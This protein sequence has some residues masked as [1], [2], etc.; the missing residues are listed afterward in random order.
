MNI[1]YLRI[2]LF[3]LVLFVAGVSL[4]AATELYDKLIALKGVTK[5]ATP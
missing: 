5:S 3:S 2:S 4:A 1:K